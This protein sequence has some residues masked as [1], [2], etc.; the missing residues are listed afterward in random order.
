M[1]VVILCGGRG[2][3]LQEETAYRPKPMVEIGGKPILWHIMKIYSHYGFNEFIL[4]LG[5]K[6]EMIKDYFFHY[7]V[8]NNDFTIELGSSNIIKFHNNHT[9]KGW[10]VTLADTGLAVMTGARLKRI[11]QYITG[12]ELM[13]TYGDGVADIDI[14]KLLGFHHKC[15]KIGTVTGVRPPSRFGELI[16]EGETVTKFSEKPLVSQGYINGGFFVFNR[17]FFDYLTVEDKCILEREPLE[18]LAEDGELM[19]YPHHGYWQCMDTY[20]DLELLQKTWR[21]ERAP[22]KVW[23]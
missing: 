20:R 7:E 15:G 22:W 16:T 19:M 8:M 5:Y 11:E 17:R 2:T 10:K 23:E 6:S 1:K 13:L 14:N 3:R 21:M 18:R 12:E 4:C 9:E